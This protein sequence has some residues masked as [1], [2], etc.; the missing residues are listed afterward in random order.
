MS[1]SRMNKVKVGTFQ[2]NSQPISVFRDSSLKAPRRR[3]SRRP[4]ITSLILLEL[5]RN[6]T[7]ALPAAPP[8]CLLAAGCRTPAEG[9]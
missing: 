3:A 7:A 6:P 8:H 1:V 9:R 4:P 5:L 2:P